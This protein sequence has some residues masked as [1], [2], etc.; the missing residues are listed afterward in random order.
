M[1]R[2]RL[3]Q[4]IGIFTIIIGFSQFWSFFSPFFDSSKSKVLNP[5]LIVIGILFLLAGWGLFKLNEIGMELSFWLWFAS[6]MGNLLSIGFLL[7]VKNGFVATVNLPAIIFL[8]IW[9]VV[10]LLVVI[11]LGQKETKKIFES[12]AIDQVVKQD[13]KP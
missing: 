4:I 8:S 12:G 3:I 11:F 10:N 1:T 5:V 13:L 2:K 7:P 6:L 9:T